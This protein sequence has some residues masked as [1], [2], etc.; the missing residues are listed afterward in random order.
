MQYT[1]RSNRPK[2]IKPRFESI[3]SELRAA[4][5]WVL[6]RYDWKVGEGTWAKVP[7][8]G[9]GRHAK[10]NDPETWSTFDNIFLALDQQ[11]EAFDGIGFVFSNDSEFVGVD[12]DAC[13][14]DGQMSPFALRVCE[15]LE[16][17]TEISPS[18][19]G[20]HLIGKAKDIQALKTKYKGND[21]EVYRAGRYFTVTG[22]TVTNPSLPVN[23]VHAELTEIVKACRPEEKK[24]DQTAE[25]PQSSPANLDNETRLKLALKNER[26]RRWFDGDVSD[27]GGDDSR[28]DLA[29][30]RSLAYWS[31][32][33]RDILDWMFRQSKLM[34]P[35]WD[36]KRGADTY[37]NITM[38]K[39]LS[40]QEKYASFAQV[41]ENAPTDYDARK[42]RRVTVEQIWDSVMDYRQS[43]DSRGVTTGWANLD[44]F[45]RPAKGLFSVVTGLPGSGKSTFV[46]VLCYQIAK[47]HD[48]KF[49]FASFET[50]PMQRHI[51]N[52]AQIAT[53]KPTFTFVKN[54]ASDKEM[55]ECKAFLN[56]HFHFIMPADDQLSIDSVLEYVADDIKDFGIEGFVLDPY[57][58]L[59]EKR[60]YGVTETEHIKQ[61]LKSFQRFTRH[62]Q[63]HSWLIAHPVKSGETYIDG[64]PSLRSIAGSQ[65]FYNKVDFGLVVHRVEDKTKIFIDK[66][67]FDVNGKIGDCEFY[68]DPQSKA[69]LPSGAI[70]EDESAAS[71]AWGF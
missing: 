71:A 9:N 48:W 6:W 34:R 59:D 56:D 21:I 8:Q 32:G 1:D 3:P 53:G 51:L 54:H 49:T 28:A 2:P 24:A 42:S 61:V 38:E 5:Q 30:V 45:Y 25:P 11:R 43:G 55:N 60:G 26:T 31:D 64:R 16:T 67:R 36:E 23:D 33:N 14:S 35:K 29:L 13:V 47:Q 66:V 65:N 20:L 57:T 15:K 40:T 62:N 7:Y 68:F 50:L 18:R 63:I 27:F 44:E 12:L 41:K 4:K 52:F 10:T 58:E 46:D 22:W 70:A 69:Y 19:T 17:Y 39:V 37:G